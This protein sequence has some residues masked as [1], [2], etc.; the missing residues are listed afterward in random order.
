MATPFPRKAFKELLASILNLHPAYVTWR[1]DKE[2]AFMKPDAPFLWASLRIGGSKRAAVGW[3][4]LRQT[5]DGNG[6][7][8]VMQVGRRQ[9]TLSLDLFTYFSP[10]IA[11][12][13]DIMDPLQATAWQPSNLALLNAMSL[14]MET[15][16]AIFP[17]PTTI[18]NRYI[19]AAHMDLVVALANID[20]GVTYP[21]GNGTIEE[22]TGTGT[23]TGDENVTQVIDVKSTVHP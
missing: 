18:D 9:I 6:G 3:D 8:S 13:D 20:A 2:P 22:V 16:S 10:D 12:A 5:D 4:D 7:F 23:Y 21:G 11:V 15:S 14:V 1:G 19:S 17:L